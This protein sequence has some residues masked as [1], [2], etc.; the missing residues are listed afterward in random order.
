MQAF[1]VFQQCTLTAF[2]GMAA[3]K[4]LR[5]SYARDV[6]VRGHSAQEASAPACKRWAWQGSRGSPRR[7]AALPASKP[8]CLRPLSPSLQRNPLP[9][10]PPLPQ[11]LPNGVPIGVSSAINYRRM[12]ANPEPA[13]AQLMERWVSPPE[14]IIAGDARSS[15][16]LHLL[17]ALADRHSVVT[18]SGEG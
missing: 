7:L 4:D 15:Y 18:L 3:G 1:G 6:E 11:T 17:C 16:Y 5:F 9:L 8:L 12:V 2:P 10:P 14:V 13:M